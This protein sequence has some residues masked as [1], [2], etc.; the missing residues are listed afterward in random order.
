MGHE[1][2]ENPDQDFVYDYELV[3]RGGLIFAAVVF[4]LGMAIIFKWTSVKSNSENPD[5]CDQA[6]PTRFTR[7]L[8]YPRFFNMGK[9]HTVNIGLL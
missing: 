9:K 7:L 3:R 1:T 4:C 6:T 8:L 5:I 2:A